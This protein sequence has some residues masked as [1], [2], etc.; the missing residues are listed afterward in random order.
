MFNAASTT[1]GLTNI[2]YRSD[3][4]IYDLVT[5]RSTDDS[6]SKIATVDINYLYCVMESYK[7]SMKLISINPCPRKISF[8]QKTL[9][10]IRPSIW[11]EK[12][13]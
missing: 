6:M 11:M 5:L 7:R 3:N 2:E 10:N 13:L 1:L 4:S 9:E 8:F 12:N